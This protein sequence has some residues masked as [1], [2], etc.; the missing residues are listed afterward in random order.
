MDMRTKADEETE[1]PGLAD[2]HC[3]VLAADYPDMSETFERAAAAGVTRMLVAGSDLRTSREAIDVADRYS[4]FGVHAAAGVHPHE[5]VHASGR[6]PDGIRELALHPRV[7]AV[8]ETGLDY[9]YDHSPRDM[10]RSCFLEHVRFA[11][12]IGKPL[13]IHGRDS[14]D[15]LRAILR[16]ETGGAARGVVHCFSGTEE[17]AADLLDM[18]LYLSFGGPLTFRRSDALRDLFRTLPEERILL[19]TDSPWLTPH[20]LRGKR[21]EPSYVRMV[22]E[23]AAEIR[24]VPLER[25]AAAVFKNAALL[26]GWADAAAEVGA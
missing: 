3:H 26:F 16:K 5:A 20:P 15:D 7:A 14:Y 10:Q 22:Y 9:Y 25:L 17:D 23:R 2:T 11:G 6:L 4:S 1:T 12:E 8:G 18:G 21:N 24:G 13:I 19:E